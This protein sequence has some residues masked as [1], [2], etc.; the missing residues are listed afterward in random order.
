METKIGGGAVRVLFRVAAKSSV[1][2]GMYDVSGRLVKLLEH[3]VFAE[4]NYVSTWD[5]HDERGFRAR[6]AVY[7]LRLDIGGQVFRRTVIWSR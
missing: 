6:P 7:F 5:G 2:L 3:G 4:G 1:R